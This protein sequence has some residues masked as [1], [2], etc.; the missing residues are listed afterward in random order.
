MRRCS[1]FVGPQIS[2]KSKIRGVLDVIEPRRR[3][4]LRRDHLARNMMS[5]EWM[6]HA[7]SF[8]LWMEP[9]LYYW[10]VILSQNI[11]NISGWWFGTFFMTFHRLGIVTPNWR[12]PSF[13]RGVGW[14]HQPGIFFR[15]R[16][17][18]AD[19]TRFRVGTAGHLHIDKESWH[20]IFV[21][22]GVT[23]SM[24]GDVLQDLLVCETTQI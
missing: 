3:N 20:C 11:P 14:N 8:W 24:K 22:Y 13:F 17:W 21:S 23:G 9:S 18:W 19:Y 2:E 10:L 4:T 1:M 12:T 6:Q 5:G 15:A 7:T 16:S